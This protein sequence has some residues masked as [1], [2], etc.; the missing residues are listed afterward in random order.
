MISLVLE[1]AY[2]GKEYTIGKLYINN[3][4]FCD[5]LED[6]DRGLT[7]TM[8]L[9]K[10]Q[11]IKIK[12]QTAIPIGQYKVAMNISSPKY[13][14]FAKYPWAK[15]YQGKLP[16]LL[17]VPG[18]SGVLIHPGNTKNDTSGCILLGT[19]DVKGKVINSQ[20]KWKEFMEIITK[21]KDNIILTIKYPR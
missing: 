15:P 9:E 2:R 14:N 11:A 12:D 18:Y 16:R 7:Y 3:K 10:I 4:Y 5:T 8:P 1:R 17:N 20:K 13:S 21:D 6:V 19:N